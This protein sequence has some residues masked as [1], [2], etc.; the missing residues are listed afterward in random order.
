MT[1]LPGHLSATARYAIMVKARCARAAAGELVEAGK[2][3][4]GAG[5]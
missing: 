2:R 4:E 1:E 5:R 3:A